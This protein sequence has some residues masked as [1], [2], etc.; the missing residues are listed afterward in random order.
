MNGA[1]MHRGWQGA[2]RHQALCC[3]ESRIVDKP[4]PD[5]TVD[6][7]GEMR[8]VDRG[9]DGQTMARERGEKFHGAL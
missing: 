7:Q 1:K 2:G 9:I 4:R 8:N 5:N 3:Q 6:G